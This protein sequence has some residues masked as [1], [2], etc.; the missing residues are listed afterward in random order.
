M[1]FHYVK[2]W[3]CNHLTLK[4][5]SLV[6]MK[7]GRHSKVD[8]EVMKQCFSRSASSLVHSRNRPGKLGV[9]V[10]DNE[11]ISIITFTRLNTEEVYTHTF[12]WIAGV[13]IHKWRSIYLAFPFLW[14]GRTVWHTLLCRLLL[15]ANKTS[16]APTW[17]SNP[18]L[19]DQSHNANSSGSLFGKP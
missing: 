9:V 8:D 14:I 12:H 17:L 2:K 6:R 11:Y 19:D 10:C 16:L 18:V 3:T 4:V 1:W 15:L 7:S 13:D 5:G